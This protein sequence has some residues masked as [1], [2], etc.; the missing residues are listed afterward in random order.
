MAQGHLQGNAPVYLCLHLL[1]C[2]LSPTLP[3][4]L[5]GRWE[6]AGLLARSGDGWVACHEG[7]HRFPLVI[8]VGG[9]EDEGGMGCGTAWL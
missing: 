2:Y 5:L 1:P 6:A 7:L 3:P 4:G 8:R 9:G